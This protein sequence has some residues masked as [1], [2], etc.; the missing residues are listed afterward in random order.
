MAR[1]A[2]VDLPREKRIVLF[3]TV[4]FGPFLVLALVFVF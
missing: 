1:I 3:A 4:R 2:G